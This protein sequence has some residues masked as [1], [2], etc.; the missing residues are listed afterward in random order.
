MN[1]R[2]QGGGVPI[3]GTSPD[4]RRRIIHQCP[5]SGN[6]N[7]LGLSSTKNFIPMSLGTSHSQFTHLNFTN[8]QVSAGHYG[9]SSLA[10]GN[11]HGLPLGKV[12][13]VGQF[14]RRKNWAYSRNLKKFHHHRHL[15]FGK[16]KKVECG[17]V[18]E[19]NPKKK[20]I[21]IS[22]PKV[23]KTLQTTPKALAIRE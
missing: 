18:Q 15:L 20:L 23:R 14:N 3:L 12:A 2:G 17:K 16:G 13:I 21:F 1:I 10:R 19:E 6:G 5:H 11:C 22:R 8:G 4:A 9:L 7:G